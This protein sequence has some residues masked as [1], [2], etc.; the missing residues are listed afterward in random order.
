MLWWTYILICLI[1]FGIFLKATKFQRE[2]LSIFSIVLIGILSWKAAIAVILL[3]GITY[4]FQQKKIT[5]WIGVFIQLTILVYH[6]YFF[7]ENWIFK[8]GLSY[9]GLQNIGIL[10]LSIRQKPQ[11]FSFQKILFA[12]TFFPKFLSGPILLPK[13]IKK[14]TPQNKLTQSNVFYGINRIV[15]GLFKLL[16]LAGNLSII[17]S[18][19]F[20]H[21]ESEF[22]AITVI[23]A[24]LL[25][26]F[27][28][29]LNFSGYTDIAL[30]FAKLFN[31]D[32]KENFNLPLRSNSVSEYW[33]KTH[34]SLI[35]W[36]TQN[37]FYYL[38]FKWRKLPNL[39]VIAGITITFILSGIWHGSAIGFLIWGILNTIYL[40]IEFL[41]KKL[42]IKLPNLIA[43]P[44]VILAVSFANL[45][46]IS[47]YWAN[48][49]HYLNNIFNADGWNFDWNMHVIAILGN[50]GYL[51]QQFQL[52]VVS[53]LVFSFL[54]FEK[55]LQK[56][57]K[58][59]AISIAFLSILAILIFVF[60]N[61]NDGS[62]F[63]YMQF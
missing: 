23:I 4:I 12:N 58:S 18:T 17:T 60:G 63:I 28:M 54:I 15:F 40:I 51:E 39:S 48:S 16:V 44:M 13:E 20:G 38:T 37:F 49:I 62:D 7:N 25:F 59:N 6:N 3:S 10:L 36:F 46:F 11:I 61:F 9:Y 47:K 19:V 24:S 55:S 50:G 53:I 2:I 56:K 22:K 1:G 52:I 21:P 26:T 5:N 35:D 45:F 31:V 32:L 34:I 33:R 30:G 41:G 42:K 43:W 27:E 14:L 8:L 57:A 29:Y